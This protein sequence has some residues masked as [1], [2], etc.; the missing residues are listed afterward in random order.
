MVVTKRHC[1][2]LSQLNRGEFQEFFYLTKVSLQVLKKSLHPHGFNVG[3]NIGNAGG[4]G[5]EHLHLHIVPRWNG[6]TNF[7]PVLG[8]TK[9]IPEYIEKT[10]QRLRYAFKRLLKEKGALKGEQKE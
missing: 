1:L 5:E 7:M 10:Y 6:D 8:E 4:A 3:I 9:I 2:D